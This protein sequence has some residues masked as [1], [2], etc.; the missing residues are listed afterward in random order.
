MTLVDGKLKLG[1]ALDPDV[2]QFPKHAFRTDPVSGSFPKWNK[3]TLIW[4]DQVL[5][6]KI[7][8]YSATRELRLS[9]LLTYHNCSIA[10]L[11]IFFTMNMRFFRW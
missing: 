4:V 6:D 8:H 2:H 11:D 3:D 10:V 9:K 7:V 5:R 1:H